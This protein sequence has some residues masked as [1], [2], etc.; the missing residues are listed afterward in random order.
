[1]TD[2]VPAA[3]RSL[4]RRL[5]R[6]S[7]FWQIV[8][9][10]S[11]VIFVTIGATWLLSDAQAG[12]YGA[13]LS[14]RYGVDMETAHAMFVDS[15]HRSLMMAAAAGVAASFVAGQV[16]VRRIL[17][18]F[19]QMAA[20]A[21]Q[22]ASGNFAVRI[23]VTRASRR[24]EVHALGSAFNRMAAQL[25]HVDTAR[26][27]MASDLTHDLLTPLT[28]LRGYIEGLRE[29]V[30]AGTPAVLTM[31]EGEIGRL[32]RLVG[33]LH[34]LTL[35]EAARHTLQPALVDTAMILNQSAS[36]VTR[37]AAARGVRIELAVAGDAV[38]LAGDAD[39]LV[40]SLQN[41][42]QNAAR[43]AVPGSTI[44]LDARR[45]GDRIEIDCTNQGPQIAHADLPL[46]FDRF[47]RADSARSREGGAGLGLAIAK[48]LVEG[49]GGSVSARSSE[50]ET[51]I[52]ISL[53]QET[54][55]DR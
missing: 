48:E 35:A 21:D 53:P 31:L 50:E 8:S 3:T 29:G 36:W 25:E 38:T 49:Q 4:S 20:Q 39:S 33:D 7:L 41:I 34:Q 26:K 15:L 27:R 13:V 28:N 54:V 47:Y 45:R 1:M 30:V 19:R 22:V 55:T 2:A 6:P 42:L 16:F 43:F 40:R 37:E 9:L 51:V 17:N 24:C 12:E 23:D 11:A 32:I 44:R 14:A 5:G 18:P 46:I 52:T 10:C